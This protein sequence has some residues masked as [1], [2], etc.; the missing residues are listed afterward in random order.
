MDKAIIKSLKTGSFKGA[1]ILR[2]FTIFFLLMSIVPMSILLYLYYQM[3]DKGSIELTPDELNVTLFLAVIGIGVGYYGMR[4]IIQQL[5]ST[6]KSSI[7]SLQDVLGPEELG[8]L[9][10]GDD[11]IEAITHSFDIATAR[12]EENIRNLELAKKTLQSVLT[13]VGSGIASMENIDSF[14]DL[15]VETVTEALGSH[16]G[17][18]LL[19]KKGKNDIYK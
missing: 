16:V 18:L 9:Q 5:M 3:K 4:I 8:S 1:S 12:L 6:T 11:E 15:I 19:I 7:K 17:V 2:K 10:D 14:L 13:R